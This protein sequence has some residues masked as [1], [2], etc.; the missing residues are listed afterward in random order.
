MRRER[1]EGVFASAL[2]RTPLP[3]SGRGVPCRD[4]S[5]RLHWIFATLWCGGLAIDKHVI[6]GGTQDKK[7]IKLVAVV[8]LI[9]IACCTFVS[10]KS[11]DKKLFKAAKSGSADDI[12][13]AI[14]KGANVNGW[15]SWNHE[16]YT[17]LMY[18]AMYNE[19]PEV[20]KAL[21][22]AGADVN[23]W[24][25]TLFDEEDGDTALMYAAWKNKNTYV[26]KALL[27]AGADVNAKNSE[28]YSALMKA[29]AFN[30]N[31][32]VVKALIAAGANVNE[33]DN[34]GYTALAQAAES[35]TNPDV[36]RALVAG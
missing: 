30:T 12:R 19:D 7:G 11:A 8:G 31:P 6:C 28:G 32:D 20:I 24:K 34:R 15:N 5:A 16:Y 10:C 35:N 18:A 21:I 14:S 25:I 23:A 13:A 4:G 22:D 9:A 27:D 1:G 17:A 36:I 2:Q 3:G 26:T 33:E 29:A